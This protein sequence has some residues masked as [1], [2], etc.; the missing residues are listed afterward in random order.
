MLTGDTGY[1]TRVGAVMLLVTLVVGVG[2]GRSRPTCGV[3][4]GHEDRGRDVR[5]RASAGVQG[6]FSL[7]EVNDFGAPSLITRTTNDV[8][9]VQTFVVVGL[10]LLVSAPI[11]MVGGV[12][13]AL[14]ENVAAVGSAG[15][16]SCR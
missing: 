16:S 15:S 4:D 2:G 10:L 1:I 13:M 8:Q 14:R 11:T 5:G 6:R 3:L 12:I 9:Q 7:R